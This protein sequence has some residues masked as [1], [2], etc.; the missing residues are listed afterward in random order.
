MFMFHYGTY[1][2]AWAW[3]GYAEVQSVGSDCAESRP[4][5]YIPILVLGLVLSCMA[6]VACNNI[7]LLDKHLAE[8]AIEY[9]WL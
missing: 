4:D 6:K 3:P 7:V 1:S 8:Q 5:N 2:Q 9:S